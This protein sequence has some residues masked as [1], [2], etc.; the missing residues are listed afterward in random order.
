MI[1]LLW[2]FLPS[3]NGNRFAYKFSGILMQIDNVAYVF[4]Q[5]LILNKTISMDLSY[6]K[7]LT[8]LINSTPARLLST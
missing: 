2:Q 3:Q 8:I 5:Q 7:S 6:H 1:K 4:I